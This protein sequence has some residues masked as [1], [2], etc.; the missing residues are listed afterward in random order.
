MSRRTFLKGLGLAP[1]T[2]L[3]PRWVMAAQ[4]KNPLQIPPRLDD[5]ASEK[6]KSYSLR[7]QA[8]T[9]EFIAGLRTPTLGINQDYLGPTVFLR[10]GEDVELNV[11]NTLKEQTTLHWHGLHV[12][13]KADGGPAQIIEPGTTWSP[14]FTVNQNAGTFWYHSHLLHKTGEQVYR[15]LA[16]LIILEDEKSDMLDLPKNYGVDD[17]P[18]IVQD[19]RFNSDGSLAYIGSPRDVMMGFFGDKTLV[20]G[21]LDPVFRPTTQRVRFRLLN[22]ANARSFT[23]AFDDQ[24]EFQ[25][26]ATDGGFIEKTVSC[27]SLVLGPSERAEIVV[28]FND[29]SPCKLISLP[30]G[31]PFAARGMMGRMQA[32][33]N[34]RSELLTIEPAAKL[35]QSP[36][37][38]TELTT[39][40]P[41]NPRDAATTRKLT[42]SMAMGMG[43]MGGRGRRG[44]GG[45][46]NFFINGQ[47]MD[48][49]VINYR[50]KKDTT[51]I[52]EITNDTMMMHPFHI[53]HSQ[54]QILDRDGLAPEAHERGLKDT[55]KV[56]PGETVRFIMRF[57]NYADPNTSYMYH[58]HIL[59]HEDNGMMG[60]FTVE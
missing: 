2:L 52:W 56:G 46:G 47:A 6:G 1:S 10:R 53:H 7:A 57:E 58:C 49:S 39:L 48:M 59:E 28:D 14:N 23:F 8:G 27:S 51:E 13:A 26:V 30:L 22:A 11:S 3:I 19:K 54:F 21:T 50:V 12:P 35:E 42:L 32:G 55:V 5:I 20:N 29:A 38:P 60:Q 9:R 45:G 33:N 34:A 17:I 36:A 15:G 24:R 40:S 31:S 25:L 37:L 41:L 43:M 4:A 16:G 18:L 44:G